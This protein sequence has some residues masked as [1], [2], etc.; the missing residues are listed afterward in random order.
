MEPI[1]LAS[2]SPRRQDYF[3]LLKLP[4]ECVSA[5]IDETPKP[6]LSPQ[7]V[8]EDLALRKTLAVAKRINISP[9]SQ[10]LIPD[11]LI[12]NPRSLIP[13][14]QSSIPSPTWI[15]GA[16]TIVVPEG[17]IFGKPAD[18]AAAGIMLKRLSGRRHEV[19]TAMA[20]HNAREN[21]TDC[22]SVSCEV[23]FAPLSDGEIEWYLDSGEWQGAAGAYRLQELGGCLIR[24]V[25]GSPS[26]VVGLPLHDFYV[27]LREN[28]YQFGA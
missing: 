6:G 3:R 25:N 12:P 8:A 7:H 24:S 11:P 19:I 1:I 27:M 23:Q 9:K 5:M 18:R 10:P 15:F 20:L 13:D 4:F 26:A 17:E 21:K 28:G 14:P 22:R 16:D 2:E